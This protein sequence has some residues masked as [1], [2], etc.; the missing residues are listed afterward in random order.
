MQ[1][2]G[3]EMKWRIRKC[4]VCGA[5]TLQETCP[6]CGSP[7]KIAHPPRTSPIDKYGKYRRIL[8]LEVESNSDKENF[9][10][11]NSKGT[12]KN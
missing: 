2:R 6:Y 10:K 3:K 1:S 4:V 11:S 9:T 7:T 8:K 5:Y 12:D